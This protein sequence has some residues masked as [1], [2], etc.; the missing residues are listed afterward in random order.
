V[1]DTHTPVLFFSTAG[2]VYKTKVYR[3]P[4]GTPQARGRALINLLPIGENEK[5]STVMPL[6]EDEASWD[7]MF[8][9]FA[10]A[11]GNV[12]RNKLSDFVNVMANGKIA[13]KL[14]E[15]DSLIDVRVCG[16]NQDVLLA[17]KLGKCIR[18]GVPDVRVFTGRTSTGVRGIR[19]GEGDS[20]ISMSILDHV[21]V[22]TAEREG[23]IRMANARRRAG[24]EGEVEADALNLLPVERFAALEAAEEM[25]LTVTAK[26]FGKRSSAYEYR[27]TGRGGQGIAN[28]ETS[29]RN[30]EVV[31]SFPVSSSDQIMLVTDAGQLIRCPVD[32]V[33]I[34]GRKTQGVVIF[35][36]D[37]DETVVSVAH[38]PDL[39]EAEGAE[40]GGTT[41][42]DD[43]PDGVEPLDPGSDDA[44]PAE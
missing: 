41:D 17:G 16:E 8:V 4:Q 32:D 24:E 7:S 11:T 5:I 19:L 6:P 36:V 38:L 42:A 21:D 30:G 25:I 1:A 23:Y 9:M 12:R 27:I 2:M 15:G 43:G 29:K 22:D 40:E 10:T 39:G 37:E 35:R 31:A 44:P 13:M 3:L 14:D 34:A 33:R 18:F 20:V 26:G 28:I